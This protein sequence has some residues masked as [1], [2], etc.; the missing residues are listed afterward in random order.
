MEYHP[1]LKRKGILARAIT[2]KNLVGFMLSESRQS[3]NTTIIQCHLHEVP[4]G[5]QFIQ[6]EKTVVTKDWEQGQRRVII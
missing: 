2:W 4:K 6:R 5:I 1:L 3:Q